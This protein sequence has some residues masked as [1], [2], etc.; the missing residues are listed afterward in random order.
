MIQARK[1]QFLE[2][3][4]SDRAMWLEALKTGLSPSRT[5]MLSRISRT[6]VYN[7][8]QLQVCLIILKSS[9]FFLKCAYFFVKE[10]K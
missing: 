3:K 9:H 7:S 1:E 4:L 6:S 10:E 8:F 5:H 2:V